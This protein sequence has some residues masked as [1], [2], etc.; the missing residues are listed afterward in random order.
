M[1]R[2]L[3]REE[4][5]FAGGSSGTAAYAALKVAEGLDENQTVVFI[6]CDTG[7]RYLS[8]YHNDEWLKE[9]GIQ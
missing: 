1:C 5:I 4:G 6:V 3:A 8:K 9:N 2:K 7:E